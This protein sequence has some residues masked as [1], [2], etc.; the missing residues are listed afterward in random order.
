[1]SDGDTTIRHGSSIRTPASC[2]TLHGLLCHSSRDWPEQ[3]ASDT[4]CVCKNPSIARPSI[5]R[6]IAPPKDFAMWFD[7]T[8]KALNMAVFVSS[9]E[10]AVSGVLP[11]RH[12]DLTSSSGLCE[13]RHAWAHGCSC[14]SPPTSAVYIPTS[15]NVIFGYNRSTCAEFHNWQFQR[16]SR[17]P[18]SR[19]CD[20]PSFLSEAIT[21][22]QLRPV[23]V[24]SRWLHNGRLVLTARGTCLSWV[25]L[26][27]S[28][29]E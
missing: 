17:E 6:E 29:M 2:C 23:R 14:I 9:L 28:I 12:F 24:L 5:L 19:P 7:S 21:K 22:C 4:S 3:C 10:A 15:N 1:M 8:C 16:H 26:A 18:C 13:R 25:G 20:S 27:V 11:E